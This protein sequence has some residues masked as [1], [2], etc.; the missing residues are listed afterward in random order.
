MKF[1]TKL[2]VAFLTIILIPII[3]SA[4]IIFALGRLQISSI[5]KTY[6]ITGTTVET[7]SNS[8]QVLGRITE[9]PYQ[10]LKEMIRENPEQMKDATC[11][12]EFNQRLEE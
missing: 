2:T 11:L 4:T 8:M 5:E 9:K 12:N 10:E 7:L 1:K 6:G 3:M